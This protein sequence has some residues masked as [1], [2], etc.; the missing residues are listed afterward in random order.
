[1][2]H[3]IQQPHL[4]AGRPKGFPQL[5]GI[6]AGTPVA[7]PIESAVALCQPRLREE[8]LQSGEVVHPLVLPQEAFVSMKILDA[9]YRSS[10][11]GKTIY[12]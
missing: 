7:L 12:F 8:P 6:R 1:M 11:T 2:L 3:L 5:L 9:V 4:P 10:E